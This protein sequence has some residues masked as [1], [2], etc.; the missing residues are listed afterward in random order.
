LVQRGVLGDEKNQII[1]KPNPAFREAVILAFLA[2]I[3]KL[4]SMG[5]P[6]GKKELKRINA[7][8]DLETSAES[9]KTVLV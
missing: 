9:N 2:S 5:A 4:L 8:V 1:I 7:G 3:V 6:T